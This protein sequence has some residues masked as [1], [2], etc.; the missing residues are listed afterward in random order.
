MW[1]T[2]R[3]GCAT[4][5][6]SAIQQALRGSGGA[7]LRE[8]GGAPGSASHGSAR[9]HR[10]SYRSAVLGAMACEATQ[11]TALADG[12]ENRLK[13]LFAFVLRVIPLR[14]CAGIRRASE[15][16]GILGNWFLGYIQG[17][18][19]TTNLRESYNGPVTACTDTRSMRRI[20]SWSCGCGASAGT[21]NWSVPAAG[22][23]STTPTT[24]GN[25]LCV[26]CPG[27]R[28]RPRYTSRCIG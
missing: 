18:P 3:E 20:R 17:C 1:D 28:L 25:G 27:A 10:A 19:A 24:A 21:A 8:C 23:S 11:A 16:M 4:A 12:R 13:A 9:E 7:S 26:T 2:G 22:A 6:Q 5:E 15:L 14:L